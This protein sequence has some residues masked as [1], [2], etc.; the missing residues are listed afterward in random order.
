MK[1][2]NYAL[3]ILGSTALLAACGGSDGGGKDDPTPTPTPIAS[4]CPADLPSFVTCSEDGD[5]DI[6]VVS[7]VID[8]DFTMQTIRSLL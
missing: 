4:S 8:E 5:L 3:A 6:Y 1:T 2:F 7:G